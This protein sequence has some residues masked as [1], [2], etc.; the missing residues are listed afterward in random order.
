MDYG[1]IM[2]VD[3]ENNS[4]VDVASA[5]RRKRKK[6]V[7]LKKQMSRRKN[8]PELPTRVVSAYNGSVYGNIFQYDEKLVGRTKTKEPGE[9]KLSPKASLSRRAQRSY[10][11]TMLNSKSRQ[12]QAMIFKKVMA[13]II[14]TDVTFFIVSTEPGY[15][16]FHI[17]Y[18]EEALVSSFFLLEYIVRLWTITESHK[19]GALGPFKGRLTYMISFH[20]IIDAFATFPFFIE[21]VSD[22]D[23]PTFTYLRFFRL[24][25]ILRTDS[26]GRAMESLNRVLYYNQ[27]ILY[28][29]G[30]MAVGL[31]MF[32]AV[33]MYYLRPHESDTEPS[34]SIATTMYYSTL[35]LTGQGGPEG[36]LPWYTKSVV[37]LTGLFSI[38]MF[39]I[40]ASMLT[41]GFEA[42]AARVAA[43]TRKRYLRRLAGKSEFSSSS[44]SSSSC[45][46]DGESSASS[47]DEEYLKL[48][49]G[50]EG[51]DDQTDSTRVLEESL[52]EML[53]T[54][55][56]NIQ[57]GSSVELSERIDKLEVKIDRIL[58]IL[59][60]NEEG[61]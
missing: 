4:R 18:H 26:L 34:W 1:S 32:T 43:K 3:G 52:K 61:G 10:V 23:L 16:H 31:I 5:I 37:L 27:E 53:S 33:L 44:S 46:A 20:A 51:G 58:Q 28:V 45:A 60:G 38:G 12:R 13:W 54:R 7:S 42:E 30:V 59:E 22:N 6:K 24:M 9:Q 40:P 57:T 49:A 56:M 48:I 36:E 11:Y 14:L 50:D 41:W 17:F 21:L 15:K 29:A 2:S 55:S 19:Y 47:S 8:G 39:A 25:R 35:M